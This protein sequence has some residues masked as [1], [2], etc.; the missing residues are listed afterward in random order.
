MVLVLAVTV[1]TSAYPTSN[2]DNLTDVNSKANDLLDSQE[3]VDPDMNHH[4]E[5]RAPQLLQLKVQQ[6]NFIKKNLVKGTQIL[7]AGMALAPTPFKKSLGVFNKV[8]IK[9]LKCCWWLTG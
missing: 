9:L 2:N 6:K 7:K 5:K 3:S 1:I 4:L 8:G